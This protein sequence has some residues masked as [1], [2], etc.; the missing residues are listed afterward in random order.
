M[1]LW[2]MILLLVSAP[3]FLFV[4]C[5]TSKINESDPASMYKDAEE[6]I[7]N[8]HYQIAIEKLKTIKNRFPYSKYAVDAQLKIADVYF[9]QELYPE[10]A[11][12]YEAFRDL[13][14]KHEKAGYAILQVAKSYQLDFPGNIARDLT[15]VEKSLEAYYDFLRRFPEAPEAAEARKATHE[16]RSLLADKELYIADFYAK[17]NIQDSAKPRYQKIVD[18]FPDTAAG[19][20]AREK[21][22]QME[23]N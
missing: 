11:T 6:D 16:I 15:V 13:H 5:S 19:K 20:S 8:D 9:R 21:L 12:S 23:S 14:P 2:I 22:S 3:A 10:A 18:L 1:R 4:G 7:S 17:R